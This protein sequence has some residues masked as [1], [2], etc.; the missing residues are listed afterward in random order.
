MC[1]AVL[2]DG[3]GPGGVFSTIRLKLEFEAIVGSVSAMLPRRLDRESRLKEGIGADFT[4]YPDA[5]VARKAASFVV[6]LPG[7]RGV[8]AAENQGD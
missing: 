8:I 1:G 5:I 3:G 4:G 6:R 7:G 2:V